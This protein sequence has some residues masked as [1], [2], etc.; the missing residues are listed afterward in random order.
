MK[1]SLVTLALAAAV[2]VAAVPFTRRETTTTLLFNAPA[3][4]EGGNTH[5]SFEAFVHF[6]PKTGVLEKALNLVLKPLGITTKLDTA[7]DR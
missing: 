4:E 5:A 7:L 6:A 3:W 2:S 1:H